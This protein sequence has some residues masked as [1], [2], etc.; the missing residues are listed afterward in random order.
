M[1]II[2]A[3][4]DLNLPAAHSLKDKR[5][6]LKSVIARVRS[7]FNVSI[8]EIEDQD[9]WQRAVLG[10]VVVSNEAAHASTTMNHLA[11]FLETA[12]GEMELLGM[13]QEMI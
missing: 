9:I 13:T 8:A 7:K 10:A 6:I 2:L 1:V 5:R 3:T 11:S 12:H 4:I